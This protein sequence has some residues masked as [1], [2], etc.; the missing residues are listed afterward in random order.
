MCSRKT[1]DRKQMTLLRLSGYAG[2]ADISTV[3]RKPN[4]PP[5][6]HP[7]RHASSALRHAPCPL[8]HAPCP[9]RH[10]LCPTRFALCAT[11]S[12]LCPE[13]C[14]ESRWPNANFVIHP[15]RHASSALR[16]APCPLHH[17]L[18]ALPHASNLRPFT[19]NPKP[20][21]Y[22]VR[23]RSNAECRPG[24]YTLHP[25]P[26]AVTY[27]ATNYLFFYYELSAMSYM[28]ILFQ[29]FLRIEFPVR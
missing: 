22:P 16:H 9:M 18:R 14:T 17:A 4:A 24:P 8:R 21:R 15:K 29:R 13:S 1:E 26:Y 10:A 6:I 25:I 2:Q 5:V 20:F 27:L 28:L 23:R 11:P 7:K 3:R 12:A 19:L